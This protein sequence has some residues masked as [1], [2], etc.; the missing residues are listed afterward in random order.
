MSIEKLC[1]SIEEMLIDCSDEVI[2]TIDRLLDC[3]I[4]RDFLDNSIKQRITDEISRRNEEAFQEF[5]K[6]IS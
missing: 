4:E 3:L 1:G 2:I 5:M 6:S